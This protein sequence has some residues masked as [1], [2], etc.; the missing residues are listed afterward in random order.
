[1]IEALLN[2]VIEKL[3]I[4]SGSTHYLPIEIF[5]DY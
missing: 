4:V 3:I 1:M 2:H 5:N